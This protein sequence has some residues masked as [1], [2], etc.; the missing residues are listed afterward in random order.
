MDISQTCVSHKQEEIAYQRIGWKIWFWG[1][2]M[3]KR[4]STLRVS[5]KWKPHGKWFQKY[6]RIF[7]LEPEQDHYKVC[8][9]NT[10]VRKKIWQSTNKDEIIMRSFWGVVGI[11][12]TFGNRS[13][14]YMKVC[15]MGNG[16]I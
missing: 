5:N 9:G 11:K 2:S 12:V 3:I 8:I 7:T 6:S 13:N 15:T 1:I 10:Y 16:R 14:K 4:F